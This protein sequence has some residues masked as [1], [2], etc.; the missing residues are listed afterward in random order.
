[1]Q[2]SPPSLGSFGED[3]VSVAVAVYEVVVEPSSDPGVHVT[4]AVSIPAVAWTPVGAPGVPVTETLFD[5]AEAV[6]VPL[7]LMA[8][9]VKV[10]AVA[11]VRPV[12]V[13]V[14]AVL[15]NVWAGWAVV[16]M[17]GVTT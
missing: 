2:V 11:P 14:V 6:P 10:Y 9:T 12:S 13:S 4:V 17:K 1:V 15:L 16:P 3:E 5:L 7:A 8:A